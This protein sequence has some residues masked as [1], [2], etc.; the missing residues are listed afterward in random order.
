MQFVSATFIPGQKEK[1]SDTEWHNFK[2][3]GE[4]FMGE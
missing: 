2:F 4:P 1:K 3:R